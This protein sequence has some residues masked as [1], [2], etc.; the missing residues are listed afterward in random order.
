MGSEQ[1][2]RKGSFR[3]PR[4]GG[5]APQDSHPQG[6]SLQF[7]RGRGRKGRFQILAGGVGAVRVA[8]GEG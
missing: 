2:F 5:K 4:R 8:V 1:S 7:S 6:V 3:K